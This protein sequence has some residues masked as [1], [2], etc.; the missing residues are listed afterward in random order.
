MSDSIPN[1]EDIKLPHEVFTGDNL[2]DDLKWLMTSFN[3]KKKD[4][5]IVLLAWHWNRIKNSEDAIQGGIYSL[6]AALDARVEKIEIA[7]NKVESLA[8]SVE[9]LASLLEQKPS[10]VSQQ[11]THELNAPINESVATCSMLAIQLKELL[12]QTQTTLKQALWRQAV[13]S[14]VTGLFIGASLI[15][16]IK[17][18]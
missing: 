4:P 14:F 6:K 3:L 16:W 7:G 11:I 9:Q 10:I 12:D 2:P 13:A 5:C 18:L 1:P 8:S 15:L 17:Y